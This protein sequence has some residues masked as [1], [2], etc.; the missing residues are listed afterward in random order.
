MIAAT[1]GYNNSQKK[2]EF[3]QT[4]NIN[5]DN[6]K[7]IT[8]KVVGN[9]ILSIQYKNVRHKYDVILRL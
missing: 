8:I 2:Y 9:F 4:F 7:L 5:N 6:N 1:R 3:S